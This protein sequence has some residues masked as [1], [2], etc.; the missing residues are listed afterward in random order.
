MQYKKNLLKLNDIEIEFT[1][2]DSK[3]KHSLNHIFQKK[4]DLIFLMNNND[5]KYIKDYNVM[6]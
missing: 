3:G 1:Y 2:T 5:H 6:L 4:E